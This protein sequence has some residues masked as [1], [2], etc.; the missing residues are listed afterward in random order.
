MTGFW[1]RP[2]AFLIALALTLAGCAS[3]SPETG[4]PT[5][6]N[7]YDEESVMDAATGFFGSGAKDLAKAIEKVFADNGRPNAYIMGSEG[8]AALVL[9]LRYG[10][11]T[12]VHKIEGERRVHWTGPSIGFDA[13]ANLSKVFVLV[14]NL[15]D[16]DD[17]YH[18]FPAVEGSF[19][20][21]GGV[22]LN[23]QQ[24]GDMVLAPIRVGVGLR[25]GANLGYMKYSKKR[26][27]LPF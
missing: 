6:E 12:L 26:R 2:F 11:G 18:R 16:T 3:S 21:I 8:S 17:L 4:T 5:E 25:A 24:K 7:T 9:G 10:D 22:G 27:L 19:Y 15:Y 14:Y 13:G 20:Y 1:G 23:Y